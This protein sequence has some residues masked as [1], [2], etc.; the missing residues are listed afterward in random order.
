MIVE[1][2]ITNVQVGM[3]VLDI[4]YPKGKF[5]LTKA[6]WL[7]NESVIESLRSKGV[8][9]LLIDTSKTKAPVV[10]L[11]SVI[12]KSESSFAQEVA[13]AKLIFDESKNIQKKLFDAAKSGNTLDLKSVGKI[14]D[15]SIDIIFKN[16]NS[17]TCVLNIRNK[18]E[19]L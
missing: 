17:L 14:T 19:Y 5:H 12:E 6:T 3:Y 18:D 7:E 1:Q 15:D 9:R 11:S 16:P 13:K 10:V 2:D 4:I 8:Q